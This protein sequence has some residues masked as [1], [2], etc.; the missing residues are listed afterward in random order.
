MDDSLN[1]DLTA[2]RLALMKLEARDFF[3]DAGSPRVERRRMEFDN[4]SVSGGRTS[5]RQFSRSTRRSGSFLA[6]HRNKMSSE[7]T[8]SAEYVYR[9]MS[10]KAKY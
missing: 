9:S 2:E 1:L 5:S 8:A 3:S 7:L 4:Q 10:R 6:A